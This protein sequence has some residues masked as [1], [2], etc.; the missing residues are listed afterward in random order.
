VWE[1]RQSR[2][3]IEEFLSMLTDIE[4]LTLIVCLA[5]VSVFPY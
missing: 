1:P 2:S 3:G 5:L 4:H